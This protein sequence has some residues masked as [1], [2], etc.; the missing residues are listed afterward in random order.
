MASQAWAL[1]LPPWSRTAGARA[2]HCRALIWWSTH[3]CSMRR[4]R[5]ATAI[6]RPRS[7]ASTSMSTSSSTTVSLT[8]P[9]SRHDFCHNTH[10]ELAFQGGVPWSADHQQPAR[11]PAGARHRR[12]QR[13][14]PAVAVRLAAEGAAVGV[15]DL[16]ESA[17]PTRSPRRSSTRAARPSPRCATSATR[18]RSRPTTAELAA[19]LGGIDTVVAC[20]GIAFAGATHEMSLDGV[21]DD[22][23]G[24]P[25]RRLPHR[26]ARPPPP[27]RGRRRID[28]HDRLGRPRSSPPASAAPTTPPRAA[29]CSSRERS[30]SSTSTHG[31][32][33]NCV[34]PGFVATDLGANTPDDHR[35]DR[36]PGRRRAPAERLDVPMSA[37]LGPG[38]DRRRRGVPLLRRRLVRHRHRPPRRRRLH[39]HLT[40]GAR[41]TDTTAARRPPSGDPL[42]G[43]LAAY[44]DAIDAGRFDDA[45]A[46]LRRRRRCTPSRCPGGRDRIPGRRPSGR[47]TCS[48]A[49]APEARSRGGTSPQPLRHR[50]RDALVEGVLVDDA[51]AA[52]R[53]PSSPAPASRG[54]R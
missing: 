46:T 9:P 15:V 50:R 37:G 53:R 7:A 27:A 1:R 12:R 4:T 42:P 5:A 41:M 44:Y 20:A 26:E 48:S 22:A 30:P 2:P 54:R 52:D 25:H 21:G 39:R 16:R 38:R 40:E 43:V 13:H 6:G 19:A 29:C 32:R 51:G 14:R 11:R 49:S 28:R 45:A 18:P 10:E 36:H 24:Q 3:T 47:P 8:L 31:I 34:C 35:P 23:P 33:A 17:P